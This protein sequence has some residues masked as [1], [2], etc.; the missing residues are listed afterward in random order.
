[1]EEDETNH[2]L[3]LVPSPLSCV[4]SD[5]G[6]ENNMN[7]QQTH[8]IQE[9]PGYYWQWE[10]E[11][12]QMKWE[13]VHGWY[14]PPRLHP[15]VRKYH[16]Y[17]PFDLQDKMGLVIGRQGHNFV[18]ITE[19]TGCYYI[20]YLSVENK[21]EVWGPPDPVHQAVRKLRRLFRRF[22]NMN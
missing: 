1:M 4:Q 12:W 11:Q 10:G 3:S 2:L 19:E 22:Q 8:I 14:S 5:F 18:R 16:V 21:I 20:F 13:P 17:V 6:R 9:F 15:E 7:T